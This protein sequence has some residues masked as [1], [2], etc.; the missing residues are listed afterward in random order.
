LTDHDILLRLIFFGICCLH[1]MT[2]FFLARCSAWQD[3]SFLLNT[4]LPWNMGFQPAQVLEGHRSEW[5]AYG[6]RPPYPKANGRGARRGGRRGPPHIGH[7][8]GAAGR[9]HANR[10]NNGRFRRRRRTPERGAG[11]AAA[12][13]FPLINAPARD[14]P[15]TGEAG[16]S[17]SGSSSLRPVQ[18][19]R[20]PARAGAPL[21]WPRIRR[22]PTSVAQ[23]AGHASM[24]FAINL[25]R[26]LRPAEQ[27][28]P[29]APRWGTRPLPQRFLE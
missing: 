15:N 17:A 19:V 25:E 22:T 16:L 7:G 29:P 1:N 9:C 18:Q 21:R 14:P 23:S 3:F 10:S 11:G 12:K 2:A 20:A 28:H 5:P 4:P 24:A 27:H 6:R 13:A 26:I 8:R